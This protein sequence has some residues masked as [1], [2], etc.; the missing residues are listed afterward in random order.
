MNIQ[1]RYLVKTSPFDASPLLQRRNGLR[2]RQG[3]VSFGFFRDGSPF[4]AITTPPARTTHE[5][6]CAAF[7]FLR[8]IDASS[9]IRQ[10][11]PEAASLNGRRSSLSGFL[12][13][14]KE[15]RGSSVALE[16]VRGFSGDWSL[17]GSFRWFI[18]RWETVLLR[19]VL[20]V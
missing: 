15:L 16:A 12:F 13:Q 5:I 2:T 1:C 6:V 18:V 7:R 8:K 9:S 19:N 14:A 11:I 3:D 4:N 17:Q 10:D 20:Y